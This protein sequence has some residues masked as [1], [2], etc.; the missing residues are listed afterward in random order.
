MV[1]D[2]CKADCIK[3]EK[4]YIG[5]KCIQ[6]FDMTI[7]NRISESNVLIYLKASTWI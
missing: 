4:N 3:C 5:I 6:V 2:L 1:H 7:S